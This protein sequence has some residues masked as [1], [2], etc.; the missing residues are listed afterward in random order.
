MTNYQHIFPNFYLL[1]NCDAVISI[2]Y[3]L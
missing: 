3:L 2:F 1:H